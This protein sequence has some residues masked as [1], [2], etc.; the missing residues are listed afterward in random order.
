LPNR[1]EQACI[2]ADLLFGPLALGDVL[3][4]N[5]N[6]RGTTGGKAVH[7]SNEPTLL[8]RRMTRILE[9]KLFSPAREH[10]TYPLRKGS[11]LFGLVAYY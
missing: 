7:P 10:R 2:E 8:G 4:S 11:S 1:I 6:P 3:V 9:R 5:N